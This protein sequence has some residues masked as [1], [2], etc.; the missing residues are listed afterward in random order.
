GFQLS[1]DRSVRLGD[2]LLGCIDE[3]QE[4][5]AALDVPQESRA[6]TS[7]CMSAL[8]EPR[9]VRQHEIDI[10]R[11][12]DAQVWMQRR[13]RII[14][15]LWFGGADFRQKGRLARIRQPYKASVSNERQPQ[16]DGQFLAGLTGISPPRRLGRR[17]LEVCIARTAVAAT[18]DQRALARLRQ[19]GDQGLLIF[20]KDLRAGRHLDD[21]V[22]SVGAGTVLAHALPAVLR[23]EMLLVAIIDQRVEVGDAF[24]PH[25]AAL[26]AV[27]AVRPA[28]FNELLAPEADRAG[29]SVAGLHVNL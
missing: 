1:A 16:P 12:H 6:E 26:A 23:L 22:L 14:R 24:R 21:A 28:E 25:I 8:D 13:K 15:D 18:R 2:V 7:A 10:A 3:M 5:A 20:G 19:I 27:A 29:A 17:R 11:T 9:Y 4:H